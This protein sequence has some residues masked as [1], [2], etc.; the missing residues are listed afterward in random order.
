MSDAGI[1]T[2]NND[3]EATGSAGG[4]LRVAGGLDVA[5]KV[6][7]NGGLFLPDGTA[8]APSVA[9]ASSGN[10]NTGLFL[11]AADSIG[12]SADGTEIGSY[13]AAGA[14]RLGP[15]SAYTALSHAV[16]G[17]LCIY[18]AEASGAANEF[19][20]LYNDDGVTNS[21]LSFGINKTDAKTY[22]DSS[23]SVGGAGHEFRGSGT[24]IGEYS[25]EGA[26]VLGPSTGASHIA[27]V[28]KS[29]NYQNN[30]G[31]QVI[32]STN[33][34]TFGADT[35]NGFTFTHSTGIWRHYVAAN[36]QAIAAS[37]V[38]AVTLGP[39]AASSF[40]S[41]I[42]TINGSEFNLDTYTACSTANKSLEFWLKSKGTNS[43]YI[44]GQV[45]SDSGSA[46]GLVID[47]RTRA[48]AA[49]ATRPL[50]NI[51]NYGTSVANCTATGAWTLGPSGSTNT[52]LTVNG[53]A[54]TTGAIAVKGLYNGNEA[55]V[56][57]IDFSG[58]A[59][60]FLSY[61]AD[62]STGGTFTF[63]SRSSAAAIDREIASATSA[64]AWT[65]GPA[66][67]Q[68]VTSTAL[69][70]F[71]TNGT[72]HKAFG[73]FSG[74]SNSLLA[75]D[76]GGAFKIYAESTA[77][78][79]N[80]SLASAVEVGAC[81]AAGAWTLGPAA[82][83]TR[84]VGASSAGASA[85]V[86]SVGMNT[87]NTATTLTTGQAITVT[88]NGGSTGYLV[89]ITDDS[90]NSGT[91]FLSYISATVVEIADPSSIFEITD[92]GSTY[93]VYK[94]ATSNDFTIKNKYGSTKSIRV[95]V[96]GG[97]VASVSNPA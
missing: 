88:M 68:I 44:F 3:T 14:W 63:I 57:K 91:F 58:G 48:G 32:N 92:T 15:E 52:N 38:G 25:K 84:I 6:F 59:T 66:A 78:I 27:Y 43:N 53:E 4:A 86:A 51:A 50:V 93:A 87:S 8:A 90:G 83:A 17:K 35:D 69:S 49:V 29:S 67:T 70:G 47:V 62:D 95:C 9:F 20:Q 18:R 10:T 11:K 41:L 55:S 54:K 24:K 7:A 46:Y 65:L 77:N 16:N 36:I 1:L 80:S 23:A 76:N 42:Q 81:T 82:N 56:G 26:W 97:T 31:F 96:I 22:Q 21:Y 12:F 34:L 60:R 89:I 40:A 85:H 61:G 72:G 13:S 75:F 94:S 79:K 28:T 2:V 74:A 71:Y 30:V 64:G 33:K 37:A 19:L 39:S 73:Y 5:K 45:D